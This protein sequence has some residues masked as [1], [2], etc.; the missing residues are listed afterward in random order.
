[1]NE[2]T[3][4][5]ADFSLRSGYMVSGGNPGTPTLATETKTVTV[6]LEEGQTVTGASIRATLSAPATWAALSNIGGQHAEPG[7]TRDIDLSAIITGAGTFSI[8]FSFRANGTKQAV[9]GAYSSYLQYSGIVIRVQYDGE[10]VPVPPPVTSPETKRICVF[11]PDSTD[12]SSNGEAILHPTSCIISEDAGGD[13][14][15]TITCPIDSDD[16]RWQYLQPGAVIKAPVP[17]TATPTVTLADSSFVYVNTATKLYTR[18]YIGY[19]ETQ[20]QTTSNSTAFQWIRGKPYAIG[21][22]VINAGGI[23]KRVQTSARI[24]WLSPPGNTNT[25]QWMLVG[26]V[27]TGKKTTKSEKTKVVNTPTLATLAV[28]DIL[29]KT[30]SYSLAW[31]RVRT[32]G[33]VEGYVQT[34]HVQEYGDASGGATIAPRDIRSQCFRI[35]AV[36]ISTDAKEITA[37]AQ[38]ISYDMAQTMLGVCKMTGAAPSSAIAIIQGAEITEE[39]DTRLIATD[40]EEPLVTG[41]YSWSNALDALLNPDNGVVGTTKCKLI[42]DN[43]DFFLLKDDKTWSG[44]R[45]SAGVNMISVDY[46]KDMSDVVTRVIPVAKD[47]NGDPYLLEEIWLDSPSIG[48]YPIPRCEVLDIG[49]QIGKKGVDADGVEQTRLT[50]EQV[51]ELMHVAA[52]KRFAEDKADHVAV[53]VQ[54]EFQHLPDTVEYESISA[55][56][57]VHLYDMV[58]VTCKQIGLDEYLQVTGYEWDCTNPDKPRYTSVTL[59]DTQRRNEWKT[60]GYKIA[61]GS[62]QYDKLTPAAKNRL[63]DLIDSRE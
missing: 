32:A 1:M 57:N 43:H 28:G 40:L 33:G 45:I 36:N 59:G 26:V 3:F 22:V 48:D 7:G 37:E 30:A 21:D 18:P 41:D 29:T 27:A 49:A 14:S 5:I 16:L 25:P 23:F 11:A 60:P 51:I 62:V 50:E 13:Y 19:T 35:Y 4:T 55:L 24:N 54:V 31:I 6:M 12:F 17:H 39:P 56:Q 38:H 44:Y 63:I 34:A 42:R 10:P 61:D 53:S 46:D 52:A 9:D 15:L 8:E 2:L 58:L 47:A 20:N